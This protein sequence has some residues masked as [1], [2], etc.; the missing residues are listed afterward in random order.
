[1]LVPHVNDCMLN[2]LLT[3]SIKKQPLKQCL[4]YGSAI[5]RC[6]T[7]KAREFTDHGGELPE[8]RALV[9]HNRKMD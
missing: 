8:L 4:F 7:P 5:C 2:T 1:M 3:T 6:K 9:N